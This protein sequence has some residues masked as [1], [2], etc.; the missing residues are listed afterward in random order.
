MHDRRSVRARSER[1]H[2]AGHPG[3]AQG[4]VASDLRD[5]H[6]R[7]AGRPGARPGHRG[8]EHEAVHRHTHGRPA[9]S[10]PSRRRRPRDAARAHRRRG[11]RPLVGA[12]HL[13]RLR[14]LRDRGARP[15]ALRRRHAADRRRGGWQVVDGA[16][17][18]LAAA[19]GVAPAQLA[20]GGGRRSCRAAAAARSS[21]R[22][23]RRRGRSTSSSPCC[24][25]PSARTARSR[26]C[27]RRSGCRTS[28]RACSARR[29]AWTRPS[30]R[31]SCATRASRWRAR[32][33]CATAST[34]RS[35]PRSRARVGEALGWPVFVKPANLGSSVGISKVHGP[36]ELTDA[37]E[38]AFATTRRRSSRSSWPGARSSAA[39]SATS[40]PWPRRSARSCRTPSGTTTRAKYDE[41]GSDIVVPADIPAPVAERVRSIALAS[42]RAL[43]LSGMARVDC[44]LG[45]DG[46]VLVNEVNT[47]PGFTSHVGLRP[48]LRGRGRR[49]SRGARPPR[50]VRAR[51]P[52]A[53]RALPLLSRR[54]ARSSAR[55]RRCS[56][57]SPC[58][59][60]PAS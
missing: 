53:A 2:G 29:R 50:A 44:F 37:L 57:R 16:P 3:R 6:R 35:T 49:L 19:E 22:T 39:C 27:S 4:E 58:P 1:G 59:S 32:S 15:G 56:P 38:L 43:E 33:C 14:P 25:A 20:T 55:P 36:E 45:A 21:A 51:A 30:A 34:T 28:A 26:A 13:A 18:L 24:T 60:A 54:P 42:F 11:G 12:R 46:E 7:V 47:I 10:R 41:G 52:R 8:D 48:P 17:A 40:G 5:G 23:A 31:P 9:R